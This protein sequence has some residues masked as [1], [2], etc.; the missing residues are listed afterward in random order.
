MGYRRRTAGLGF[1]WR[2]TAVSFRW[3]TTA[4][5]IDGKQQW[6]LAVSGELQVENYGD[7]L[8]MENSGGLR[9]NDNGEFQME[10]Y[11]NGL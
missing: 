1:K 8:H 5:T 6:T 11:C 7:W 9:K 2:T 10:N 4:W 3:G